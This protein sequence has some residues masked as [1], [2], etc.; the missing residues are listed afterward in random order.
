MGRLN[1][2]TRMS[3]C[4]LTALFMDERMDWTAVK[5]RLSSGPAWG[6]GSVRSDRGEGADRLVFA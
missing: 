4:M 3:W 2:L 6:E 1:G 5:E